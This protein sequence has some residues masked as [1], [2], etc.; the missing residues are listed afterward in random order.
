T[1][2]PISVAIASSASSSVMASLNICSKNSICSK[3]NNNREF[4]V[5]KIFE[6][7]IE[8]YFAEEEAVLLAVL[9]VAAVIIIMTLGVVLAPMLTALIIAFLMQ[10]MVLRLVGWGLPHLY[11]VIMAFLVLVSSIVL[12]LL[13][14]LPAL[15]QQGV[16]L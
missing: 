3:N 11:A 13:V 12:G 2:L 10:G 6:R 16:T 1:H 8:R 15:W 5:I 4:C 7:W 14:L 9:L